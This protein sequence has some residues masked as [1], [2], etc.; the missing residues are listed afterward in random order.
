MTGWA[1]ITKDV[2]KRLSLTQ[3]ELAEKLGV[4][5]ASVNRWEQGHHEPTMKERRKLAKICRE[6]GMYGLND[7]DRDD[8][9]DEEIMR[10]IHTLMDNIPWSKLNDERIHVWDM[11]NDK[12]YGNLKEY[13]SVKMKEL[14][15]A[16]M[17]WG[18]RKRK[19]E[20]R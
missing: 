4:C 13:I 16:I 15:G 11:K 14:F 5:Y 6:L 1:E 10:F 9:R 2:R 3:A 7:D 8:N 19:N 12:E 20:F 18:G 17:K